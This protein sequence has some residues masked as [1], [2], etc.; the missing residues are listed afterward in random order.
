MEYRTFQVEQVHMWRRLSNDG[1]VQ[2][3]GLLQ[4]GNKPHANSYFVQLG[5]VI[6]L[7]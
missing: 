6:Q 2:Q 4:V 1:F 7:E 3:E 5:Y